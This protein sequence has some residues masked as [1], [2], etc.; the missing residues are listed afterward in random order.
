L[1][2]EGTTMNTNDDIELCDL[3]SIEENLSTERDNG[4]EDSFMVS[5]ASG[6]MVSSASGFMVS[7]ASGFMVS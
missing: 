1:N 7:S 3:E 6:F 4:S 2:K 5:S